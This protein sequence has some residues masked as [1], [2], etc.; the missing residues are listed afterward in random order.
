M[1]YACGT[2]CRTMYLSIHDK[3][4]N[5]RDRFLSR[6]P[7]FTSQLNS[8]VVRVRVRLSRARPWL[9]VW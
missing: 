1:V 6:T 5:N 8:V 4:K 2:M 3:F 7:E 9:S